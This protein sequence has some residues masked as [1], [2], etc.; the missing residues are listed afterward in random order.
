[1]PEEKLPPHNIE[2]EEAV[3]GSLLLWGTES[4]EKILATSDILKPSDFLREKNGWI[5]Q[6]MLDLLREGMAVDHLTVAH[7]LEAQ[8]KLESIGGHAYLYHVLYAVP[9]S[10]HL[11]YYARIVKDF[12]VRRQMIADAGKLAGTAYDTSKPLLP[13]KNPRKGLPLVP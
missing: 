13:M 12:S 1:M 6:A 11:E 4:N 5:Y 9:T 8:E 10:M 2:A 3:L 7:K